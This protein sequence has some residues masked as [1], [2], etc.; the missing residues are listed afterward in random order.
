MA[1]VYR[2]LIASRSRACLL[3]AES[4]GFGFD[5]AEIP[6][7]RRLVSRMRL[8]KSPPSPTS[9]YPSLH[10]RLPLFNRALPFPPNDQ[11]RFQRPYGIISDKL[12]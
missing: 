8:A 7:V 5:S 6:S 3:R 10:I 12:L 2:S 9:T 11:V 4:G 1:S